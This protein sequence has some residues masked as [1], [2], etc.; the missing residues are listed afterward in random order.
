MFFTP[1]KVAAVVGCLV[2]FNFTHRQAINA[3][4]KGNS[5]AYLIETSQYSKLVNDNEDFVYIGKTSN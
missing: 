1:Q 5:Q 4:Y 3:K 2:I